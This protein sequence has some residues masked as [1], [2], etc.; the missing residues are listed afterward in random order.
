MIV[1]RL[2][3]LWNMPAR[4]A[5]LE[6]TQRHTAELL[7]LVHR[8]DRVSMQLKLVALLNHRQQGEIERLSELLD[9][10]RI[11]KHVR[12]AVASAPL[13]TEPY[14]HV[15]VE[16]V[17]PDD[18]YELLIRAMPPPEFFD[19]KKPKQN[20]QLPMEFGPKLS[21][22]AW[23]F[24]DDAI[25]CRMIRPAVLEKFHAPLQRHLA[26]MF[27]PELLE[28]A[29]S[30]PQ[31]VSGGLLMLR[32]PGYFIGPHRDPKRA[33]LTCLF[34]LAR[35]G[36]NEA[37]GTQI[38]RVLEDGEAPYKQTYYPE[39]EGRTCELVKVV[40]FKPN[41]MLVCLNSRGA[42]GAAIPADA[43]PEVERYSYQFYVAPHN[44]ALAA[45]V[46]SSPTVRTMWRS[47]ADVRP[48]YA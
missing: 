31:S 40:P 25:A 22:D 12:Q 33:M 23:R 20:L 36:D 39:Q 1:K 14:E 41:T 48:E 19:E 10:E 45:L 27:G 16:R 4:I 34:Y 38:F 24:M 11:D 2:K 26:S 13:L 28:Q 46:K 3:D 43:P 35:E 42:H 32:R 47:K 44:E 17:L 9:E 8:V 5:R 29:N 21:A 6:E 30:L 37:Y 15:V 7:Q 18:V